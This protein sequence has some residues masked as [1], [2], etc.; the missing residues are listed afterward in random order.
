MFNQFSSSFKS[1]FSPKQGASNQTPTIVTK[2]EKTEEISVL[3]DGQDNSIMNVRRGLS[4]PHNDT[5]SDLVQHLD[6]G[7][8]TEIKSNTNSVQQVVS[9]AVNTESD[10]VQHLDHGVPTEIASNT[11]SVQQVASCTVK[12]LVHGVLPTAETK[13]STNSMQQVPFRAVEPLVH[14]VSTFGDVDHL[15]QGRLSTIHAAEPLVQAVSSETESST[16]YVPQGV[17]SR[18]VK[19]LVQG[20]VPTENAS[21]SVGQGFHDPHQLGP[22]VYESTTPTTTPPPPVTTI[23]PVTISMLYQ[24]KPNAEEDYHPLVLQDGRMVKQVKFLGAIR[25]L[26]EQTDRSYTFRVEDGTGCMD[27]IVC[28][29]RLCQWD[30][31]ELV[32]ICEENYHN[33]VRVIGE[34]EVDPSNG[35]RIVVADCLRKI[36][37]SNEITYHFLQVVF[38]VEQHSRKNIG[39]K[40]QSI[41]Q[42]YGDKTS[43]E[44]ESDEEVNMDVAEE[45]E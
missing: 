26:K 41:E 30:Q 28:Y 13:S 2:D 15:V 27:V 39:S 38:S 16:N 4:T 8:P 11:N 35:T 43:E 6:Y 17:A 42:N 22:T 45:D 10:L 20:R 3:T 33:Y 32:D 7:V 44:Q 34:I 31:E 29:T 5:E 23:L 19:H 25:A 14:G 24:I 21:T 12:H 18:T 40:E 37:T 9:C 36:I 1:I